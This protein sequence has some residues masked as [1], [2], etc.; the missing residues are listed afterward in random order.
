[1]SKQLARCINEAVGDSQFTFIVGKH[2]SDCALIAHKLIDDLS[3][4][5]KEA[6]ML[7]ADFEKAYDLVDWEFLDLIM[8]S[9]GFGKRWQTWMSLC[10]S[11]TSISVLVNVSP[12]DKFK[13][14]KGLRQGLFRKAEEV[15]LIKGARVGASQENVSHIQFADDIILF[16]ETN[17]DS[18]RNVKMILRLFE[19]AS[20]LSLNLSKTKLYGINLEENRV[21]L[22]AGIIICYWDKFPS[23]Y[24]GLPLGHARNSSEIW[25]PVV[26]KFL[27]H[28]D[29]W[30]GKLLSFGGRLT[31]V[32]YVLSNLSIYYLSV[33]QMS[34]SVASKLTRIVATF[35][36]GPDPIELSIGSN[37]IVYVF[38]DRMVA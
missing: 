25:Q 3:R 16:L 24:L 14:K 30:K 38:Q 23:M 17:L 4:R 34:K 2:I 6:V 15:G 20:G 37:G 1:M 26:N 8:K 22:W 7:K 21:V 12:T 10:I 33:F 5:K 27:T 29:G 32:K 36:W 11:T 28:L 19:L 31:L 35:L 18:L 9:M 13:I